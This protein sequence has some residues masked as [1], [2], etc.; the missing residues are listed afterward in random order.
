MKMFKFFIC[1]VG[2]VIAFVLCWYA[3][4]RI[5][6]T[7]QSVYSLNQFVID[8]NQN[9]A[10]GIR[11][12]SYNMA[13]GR[14]GK[15]GAKNRSHKNPEEH[16]KHLNRIVEQIKEEDPDIVLL[17]EVDFASAWSF[18]INQ[19]RY[20]GEKG[21]YSHILEQKNM[22]V[23]FP[24]FRYCFGNALLSKFPIKN[25]LFIDFEPLSKLEDM[26]IGNHDAFF[27]ELE[28]PSG[29]AGVFGIH[30]EYRSEEIRVR[31]A[32]HLFKMC[33]TLKYPVIIL[34]D[35]NS[36]L[37]GLP[38]VMTSESG[39]NAMGSLLGKYGF[40]SY[41]T[42]PSGKEN[43]TFPSEKPD[44]LIDWIIAK[45]IRGFSNSKAI[46]SNLS[47]HLMIVTEIELDHSI[48]THQ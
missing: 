40:T 43:Y 7:P 30:L 8:E 35:F 48:E 33:S 1:L 31:C 45:N 36:T 15:L 3:V 12:A 11:V 22:D 6:R 16:F 5:S 2:C 21:G 17:N 20:I 10:G 19:A 41:L 18:N 9:E 28:L 14:G 13:H 26:F 24:F 34:G 25:E 27:C 32:D 42:E 44:R 23:S 29:P 47:D 39:E 37:P 4:T 46:Q 38:K